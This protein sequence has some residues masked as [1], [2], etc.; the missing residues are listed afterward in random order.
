ML[1]K[2]I[3]ASIRG[4]EAGPVTVETDIL[5]GL[6]A[7]NLVGQADSTVKEARERIRSALV[8]S[9]MEYPKCRL[10]STCPRR[11]A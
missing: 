9:G 6:P 10:R 2:I 8:N 4:I 7:F 1:S 11:Y 3:S 5:R